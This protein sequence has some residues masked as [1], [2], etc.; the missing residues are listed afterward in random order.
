MTSV[1]SSMAEPPRLITLS[2]SPF[3]ELARWSLEWRGIP[4]REEAQVLV[5]HA[6][7][8]RRAG[9]QGTTPVLIAGAE[10]VGESP[11]IAEW[12]DRQ[13]APGPPLFPEGADGAPVRRFVRRQVDELGPE[14][15]RFVWSHLIDDL[16]LADRHW[17]EGVEERQR[18][19]QPY[20]LR[21]GRP[22]IKRRLGLQPRQLSGNLER[23]KA[24]FDEIAAR[25]D[26]GRPYLFG[27]SL[28]AADIAFAAM[29]MPAI[30]PD[31]GF[32][33][34]LP[35]PSEMGKIAGSIEELRAHPAGQFA[36]RLYAEDRAKGA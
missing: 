3:N 14:A 36:L 9:G 18:R 17:A 20:L 1:S 5:W 15:R 16:S 19:W 23:V 31:R 29:A 6:I 35:E 24:I 32:P 12:A 11:A 4:Y 27:D 25:I 2:I 7:A 33:V 10:V 34:P 22:V 21:A 13:P 26:D 8:S 28:T 30:L